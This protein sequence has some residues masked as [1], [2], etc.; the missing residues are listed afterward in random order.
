MFRCGRFQ[1]QGSAVRGAGR[2]EE[3]IRADFVRHAVL[4]ADCGDHTAPVRTRDQAVDRGPHGQLDVWGLKRG[5][6]R[7]H[8]GVVLGAKTARKTVTGGA[9]NSLAAVPV[10]PPDGKLHGMRSLR[11]HA[12]DYPRYGRRVANERVR[13][14]RLARRRGGVVARP[15]VPSVEFLRRVVVTGKVVIGNRPGRRDPT[16]MLQFPEVFRP[17][18]NQHGTPDLAASADVLVQVRPEFLSG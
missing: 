2:Y 3:A 8:F 12:L 6:D 13:R 9:E 18:A 10:V 17:H 16:L 11:G 15:A 4:L 5:P 1:Q 7:S 14:L